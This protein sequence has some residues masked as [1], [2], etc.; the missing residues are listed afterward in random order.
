MPHKILKQLED[1]MRVGKADLHIHSN[2]SDGKPSI[3]EILEY[4]QD[5]TD[6]DVIAITDHDTIEG[7]VYAKEVHRRGDY[8]F[9]LIVG[10]EVSSIEGHIIGLFLHHPIKP[11]LSAA[12][13]IDKIKEQG[14]LSIAVHP[15]YHTKLL[16]TKMVVMNGIGVKCIFQNHHH[17]DAIEIVNATPTLADENLGA[18]IMNRAM[19]Y[20]AET[21]SSDAHILEAIG[22]AYTAFEGKTS[23]DLLKTIKERQSQAIYAGWTFLS[24]LK[25]LWF[26]VP[27]GFRLLWFNLFRVHEQIEFPVTAEVLSDQQ[28]E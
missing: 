8:R 10:E 9:D 1:Y 19:L 13:T 23:E 21:G 27:I 15:F 26:F 4:V 7:A 18:A 5:K 28:N 11:G 14:G 20:R 12:E 16:N 22:R 24:L 3:D 2:F 17:L 6:L 25:Y